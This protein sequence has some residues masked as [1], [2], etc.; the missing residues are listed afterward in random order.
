MI[1]MESN[2]EKVYT[3]EDSR[4]EIKG[5][6]A[7]HYDLMMN[8]F[9][10]GMYP[11]FIRRVIKA[12]NI[13]PGDNILVFGCGTGRN[14]ALM[15]KYLK[16]SG[17]I[18]GL[19]IGDEML[20]QADRKFKNH[21]YISA[22]KKN[23]TEDLPYK[24]EFDKVFISFVFHG[25][26]QEDRDKVIAN[27]Y[28]ALKPGGEFVILDYNEIDLEKSSFLVRFLFKVECPLATEFIG[29]DLKDMLRGGGF[30]SFRQKNF[31]WNKVRLLAAVKP[32]K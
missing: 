2:T 9:T 1:I 7:R 12:V 31:G 21:P 17:R 5:R 10:L 30:E 18:L 28:K 3:R 13:A 32:G 6:E 22:E 25:L 8:V 11:F 19:D 14:M 20:E 29:K 16:G 27:A 23:I 26:I 4:V 24:E 15:N